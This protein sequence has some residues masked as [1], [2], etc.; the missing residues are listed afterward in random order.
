MVYALLLGIADK[1]APQLRRLYPDLQ[2][3]IDQYARR[4][5]WPGTTTT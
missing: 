3:E 2:P 4:R 5:A 1:V